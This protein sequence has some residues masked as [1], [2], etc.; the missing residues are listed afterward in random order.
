MK[1]L[2]QQWDSFFFILNMFRP[3]ESSN[4]YLNKRLNVCNFF[5]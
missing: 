5:S 1:K 3:G 4:S 2:S